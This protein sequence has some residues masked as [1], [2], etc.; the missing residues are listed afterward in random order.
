MVN[1]NTIHT[2][3]AG[4]RSIR[5]NT[6]ISC[7]DC[8]GFNLLMTLV[9]CMTTAE[10]ETTPINYEPRTQFCPTYVVMQDTI[11]FSW[12]SLKGVFHKVDSLL[13]VFRS[14]GRCM[15]MP[16]MVQRDVSRKES[17]LINVMFYIYYS[18]K[19]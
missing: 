12:A 6:S 1:E 10:I 18:S 4:M 5:M 8:S 7:H 16:R 19:A 11:D 2:F 17:R 14:W 3:S 9:S 15:T 13:Q